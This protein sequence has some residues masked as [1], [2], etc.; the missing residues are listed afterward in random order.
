VLSTVSQFAVQLGDRVQQ[1]E[2]FARSSVT[3]EEGVA[4]PGYYPELNRKAWLCPDII[5]N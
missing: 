5:L 3:V 2:H 1:L 4:M